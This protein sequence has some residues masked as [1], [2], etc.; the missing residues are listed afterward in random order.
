MPLPRSE[1]TNERRERVL[2]LLR[3]RKP[4]PPL[5]VRVL[6]PLPLAAPPMQNS[7]VERKKQAT[8]AQVK[9]YAYLPSLA[10]WPALLKWLRPRTL[11]AL[12]MVSV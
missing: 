9:P 7:T 1:S 12:Y 2:L 10:D 5:R 8:D 4:P 11:Q 6:S 3:P